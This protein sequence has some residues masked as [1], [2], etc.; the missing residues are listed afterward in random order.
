MQALS[1]A[2]GMPRHIMHNAPFVEVTV[3]RQKPEFQCSMISA[4]TAECCM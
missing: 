1:E 3:G 4:K 2:L